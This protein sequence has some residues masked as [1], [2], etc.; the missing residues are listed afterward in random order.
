MRLISLLVCS[1]VAGVALPAI[2]ADEKVDLAL[3]NKI[4]D[5]GTESLKVMETLSVLTD[6]IGPRLTS[7]PALKK[8]VSGHKNN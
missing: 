2:A 1:L 3:V 5:E 6:E 4:R 8:P 7:S